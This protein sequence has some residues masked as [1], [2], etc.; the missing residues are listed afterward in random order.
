M[1]L[2]KEPDVAQ[3]ELLTSK[4]L[5]SNCFVKSNMRSLRMFNKEL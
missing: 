5:E 3:S 2:A 1:K 4:K